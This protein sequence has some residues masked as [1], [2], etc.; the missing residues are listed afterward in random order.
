MEGRAAPRSDAKQPPCQDRTMGGKA[1][2]VGRVRG[3]DEGEGVRVVGLERREG[4][5]TGEE[6]ETGEGKSGTLRGKGARRI[7]QM[8]EKSG[9]IGKE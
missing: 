2:R 5:M 9:M 1:G 4:K 3:E 8:Y 7:R 6:E